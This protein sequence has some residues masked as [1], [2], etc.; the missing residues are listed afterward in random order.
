MNKVKLFEVNLKD[1]GVINISLNSDIIKDE[2]QP[3]VLE[4]NSRHDRYNR[5]F[6]VYNAIY[7]RGVIV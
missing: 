3:E 4:K 7:K 6:Y 2:D 1:G 5:N